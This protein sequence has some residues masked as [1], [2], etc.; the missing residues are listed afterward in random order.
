[1]NRCLEGKALRPKAAANVGS[2][3]PTDLC[4]ARLKNRPPPA[5]RSQ[6]KKA[7]LMVRNAIGNLNVAMV[8][9]NNIE[10]DR[11]RVGNM[12][13][14][15]WLN[16]QSF[17]PEVRYKPLPPTGK[18]IWKTAPYGLPGDADSLPP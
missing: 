10:V 11:R 16:D 6:P 12:R 14:P 5:T 18:T 17:Y 4:I 1:M 9:S 8:P 2:P 15:S 13:R 3:Q 7:E